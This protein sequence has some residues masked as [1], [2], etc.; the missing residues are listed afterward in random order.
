M[1][2]KG[3]FRKD[4]FDYKILVFATFKFEILLKIFTYS[5]LRLVCFALDLKCIY[6]V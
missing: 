1:N 6:A 2:N 5:L 3:I 4:Y